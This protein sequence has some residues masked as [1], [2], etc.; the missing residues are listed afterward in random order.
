MHSPVQ[1]HDRLA[2]ARRAR[3]PRRAVEIALDQ[4]S[5]RRMEKDRPFVPGIIQ[6]LLQFVD[7]VYY[8]ETTLRIRMGERVVSVSAALD[9]SERALVRADPE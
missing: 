8:S 2:R 1:R 9:D 3:N 7:V 5:L 4:L 6:R